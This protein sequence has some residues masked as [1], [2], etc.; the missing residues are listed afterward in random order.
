MRTN[1]GGTPRPITSYVENEDRRISSN[2]KDGTLDPR[3]IYVLANSSDWVKFKSYSQD[4]VDAF[5]IDGL[6]VIATRD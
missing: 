5:I 1:F 6:C 2:F 4:N 3:T